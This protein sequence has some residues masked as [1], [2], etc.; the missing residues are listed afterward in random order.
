MYA[1]RITDPSGKL[2]GVQILRN[3]TTPLSTIEGKRSEMCNM[4]MAIHRQEAFF[5]RCGIFC[6]IPINDND[7][8]ALMAFN[9]PFQY[10]LAKMP[11]I[12]L[13]IKQKLYTAFDD[14]SRG[15]NPVWLGDVGNND[16]PFTQYCETVVLNETFSSAELLKENFAEL[17]KNIR[18]YSDKVVVRAT[19]FKQR[20]ILHNAGV[21]GCTG[22][23]PPLQFRKIHLLM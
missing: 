11:Y 10:A 4:L 5:K 17:I 7:D 9:H 15:C 3:E 14:L 20:E 18:R 22:M 12:N 13:Q 16:I 6:T 8:A 19:D 21:W 1:E 23:Y 2:L